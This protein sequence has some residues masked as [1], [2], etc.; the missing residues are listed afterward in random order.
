MRGR[1]PSRAYSRYQDD[2]LS[3]VLV[4][5]LEL[6][7][8]VDVATSPAAAERRLRVNMV[9]DRPAAAAAGYDHYACR[10]W[11]DCGDGMPPAADIRITER[12][13]SGS[14]E[15]CV[16]LIRKG[17][18]DG[19]RFLELVPLPERVTVLG[20]EAGDTLEVQWD[21]RLRFES[22]G[23]RS[24]RISLCP[25]F[26][27]AAEW[28]SEVAARQRI[29]WLAGIADEG[30]RFADL[31]LSSASDYV[32]AHLPR[33]RRV[34]CFLQADHVRDWYR[35][36]IGQYPELGRAVW[37]TGLRRA[38]HWQSSNLIYPAQGVARTCFRDGQGVVVDT[39][40]ADG[41]TE[42]KIQ[43]VEEFRKWM[44]SVRMEATVPAP[45]AH[46]SGPGI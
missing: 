14:L 12:I 17:K 37:M 36:V 4:Q 30:D 25:A 38:P 11:I 32:R 26:M 42:T 23:A 9:F 43:S 39:W 21:I 1:K 8:H 3:V 15:K 7:L 45:G 18:Q 44:N 24:V 5:D 46:G 41:G 20:N 28:A 6:W 2:G 34:H 33:V 29:G 10:G 27:T 13:A 31:Y 40:K 22:A 35:A 19:L 16:E